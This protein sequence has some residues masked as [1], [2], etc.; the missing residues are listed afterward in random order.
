M[1]YKLFIYKDFLKMHASNANND[2]ALVFNT[3]LFLFK[4]T[5]MLS[6]IVI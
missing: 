4:N 1:K 5:M 2:A 6:K 3:V